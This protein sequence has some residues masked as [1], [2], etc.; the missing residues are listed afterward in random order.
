MSD[1]DPM[2]FRYGY[3]GAM[4]P[5]GYDG[6]LVSKMVMPVRCVCRRIYDMT[7]VE[8]IPPRNAFEVFWKT[9]CCGRTA[10]DRYHR[11]GSAVK[12]YDVL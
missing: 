1:D 9:P 7:K 4:E 8:P 2:V 3:A 6:T 11:G 10:D 12:F 5:L